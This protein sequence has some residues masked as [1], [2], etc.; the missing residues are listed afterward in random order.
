MRAWVV[1]SFGLD[2]VALVDRPAPAPGPGEVLVRVKAV[3]LNYRDLLIARGQ[4]NP[5]MQLPRVLCSDAAGEVA[6]IG[7]GVAA[8]KP[9]DRVAGCFFQ[10][11]DDGPLTEAA[12]KSALGGDV[13]GV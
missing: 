13:D 8:W 2:N 12:T 5:R 1:T 10:S 11:W 3:S 7:P 9:G 6:G 4:Y